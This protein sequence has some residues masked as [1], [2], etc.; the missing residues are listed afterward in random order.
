MSL[1]VI[2]GNFLSA[3]LR[4]QQRNGQEVVSVQVDV[5]QPDS[6]QASKTVPVRV[7]EVT[8]LNDFQMKYKPMDR[9]KMQCTVNAYQNQAYYKM[10][11]LLDVKA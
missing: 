10:H 6:P 7:D 5:Y 11:K 3:S 2:E 9:I 8:A 1:V 4:S